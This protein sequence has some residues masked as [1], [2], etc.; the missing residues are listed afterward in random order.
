MDILWSL[1]I[2]K[3]FNNQNLNKYIK[4][5]VCMQ[6]YLL[7]AICKYTNLV[8]TRRDLPN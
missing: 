8:E 5:L 6:L 1:S 4:M 3:N 7:Q 2:F